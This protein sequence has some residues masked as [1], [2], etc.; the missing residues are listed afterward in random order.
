LPT[1]QPDPCFSFDCPTCGKPLQYIAGNGEAE[2][3]YL[4][5]CIHDGYFVLS[6]PRFAQVGIDRH[7]LSTKLP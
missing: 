1:N 3:S 6:G 2:K 7:R 5:V 4:Y